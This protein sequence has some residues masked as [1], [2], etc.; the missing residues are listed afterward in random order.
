MNVQACSGDCYAISVLD[1]IFIG[2]YHP[3]AAFVLHS[4][5][6]ELQCGTVSAIATFVSLVDFD[7][8]FEFTVCIVNLNQSLSIIL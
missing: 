8:P 4:E 7:L 6:A 2:R 5:A 3:R 1:T